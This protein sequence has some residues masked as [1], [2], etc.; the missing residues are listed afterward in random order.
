MSTFLLHPNVLGHHNGRESVAYC[1]V[2]VTAV[3]A[4]SGECLPWPRVRHAE[5]RGDMRRAVSRDWRHAERSR[6]AC[7]VIT[8]AQH[9]ISLALGTAD[10]ALTLTMGR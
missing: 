2:K 6:G 1:T 10:M 5:T 7:R 9:G 4:V 3:S 8:G